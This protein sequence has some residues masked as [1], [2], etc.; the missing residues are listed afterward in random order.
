HLALA[1]FHD[2]ALDGRVDDLLRDPRSAVREAAIEVFARSIA[3]ARKER[4]VA[5]VATALKDPVK[6]VREAAGQVFH[7]TLSLPFDGLSPLLTALIEGPGITDHGGTMALHWL[8]GTRRQLPVL[9]LDVCEAFMAP[10]GK[11]IGDIRTH[12]SADSGEIVRIVLRLHGQ[13]TERA[14]RDRCLDLVDK[15][16]LNRA[17]GIEEGL[18]EHDQ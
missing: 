5:V 3:F 7:E 1:S 6:E 10:A 17:H 16:L 2:E 15:L 11:D 8:A 4:C 13:H 12:A 9:A 14:I 18:E